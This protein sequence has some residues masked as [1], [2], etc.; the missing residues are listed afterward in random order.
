MQARGE[1]SMS[2]KHGFIVCQTVTP[3]EEQAY[4]SLAP[5]PYRSTY[6]ELSRAD[7]ELVDLL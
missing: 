5:R 4:L 7:L 2:D 1:R 3:I 6:T